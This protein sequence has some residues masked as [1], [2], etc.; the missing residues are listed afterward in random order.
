MLNEMLNEMLIKML[1]E[2]LIEMLFDDLME[3]VKT[4]SDVDDASNA[5][6][7]LRCCQ[8]CCTQRW[9]DRVH[10]RVCGFV[11][12]IASDDVTV[13]CTDGFSNFVKKLHLTLKQS[14]ALTNFRWC[15]K[16]CTLMIECIDEFSILSENCIWRWN[17]QMHWRID[18][19]LAVSVTNVMTKFWLF[20]DADKSQTDKRNESQTDRQTTKRRKWNDVCWLLKQTSWFAKNDESNDSIVKLLKNVLNRLQQTTDRET[21]KK[22]AKNLKKKSTTMIRSWR[23]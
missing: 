6:T 17:D 3:F 21:F 9:N 1:I 22:R 18:Y 11:R 19:D 2:I 4:A 23:F 16:G 12:K 20:D 13:R 5:Q 10:W 7:N 15:Q 14:D 8:K